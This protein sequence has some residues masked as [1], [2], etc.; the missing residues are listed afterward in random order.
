MLVLCCL[1]SKVVLVAVDS[2]ISGKSTN[3]L[4]EVTSTLNETSIGFFVGSNVMSPD[5]L[6]FNPSV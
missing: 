5:A 3:F 6:G 4:L 2:R 1:L